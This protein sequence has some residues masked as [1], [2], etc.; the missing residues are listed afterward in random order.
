MKKNQITRMTVWA[1]GIA[2]TVFAHLGNGQE[3]GFYGISPQLGSFPVLFLSGNDLTANFFTT[4]AWLV[5][6]HFPATTTNQ[7]ADLQIV[8]PVISDD[9]SGDDIFTF[10]GDLLLSRSEEQLLL[11]GQAE[12]VLTQDEYSSDPSFQPQVLYVTLL[13][14]PV[15]PLAPV[16]IVRPGNL[17]LTWQSYAGQ[18]YEVQ[19]KNRVD[20]PSWSSSDL[21]IIATATNTSADIPMTGAAAFYRVIQVP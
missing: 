5:S 18:A 8:G 21:A 20:A 15:V 3:I 1:I 13:D 9:E 14:V 2:F 7:A 6:I 4:D 10:S 12:L 11:A 19:F 16:Q 17:R